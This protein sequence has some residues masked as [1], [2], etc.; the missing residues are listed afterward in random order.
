MITSSRFQKKFK[1]HM[2]AIFPLLAAFVLLLSLNFTKNASSPEQCRLMVICKAD[3]IA[4]LLEN[5]VRKIEKNDLVLYEDLIAEYD[6]ARTCYASVEF[7][8]EYYS[9]FDA[10]NFINPENISGNEG[11]GFRSIYLQLQ[12]RNANVNKL[13]KDYRLLSAKFR[14]LER[15]YGEMEIKQPQ[16]LAAL[17]LQ[18]QQMR[19]SSIFNDKRV[20]KM[21][22]E[23]CMSSLRG[24]SEAMNYLAA[25]TYYSLLL[26]ES[27]NTLKECMNKASTLNGR[28]TDAAYFC[29]EII[30][31]VIEQMTQTIAPVPPGKES[32]VKYLLS[33]TR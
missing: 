19:R 22:Q 12:S 20:D 23:L 30:D 16:L 9:P 8:V 33:Q 6:S 24:I 27:H 28:T 31:P 14:D 17:N 25:D 7:F 18:L 4:A 32:N 26:E 1:R 2:P 29:S 21:E 15:A 3:R 11:A 10:H 13:L 5:S